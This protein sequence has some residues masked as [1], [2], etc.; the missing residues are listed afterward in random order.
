MA[1]WFA[2]Y[3]EGFPRPQS[4]EYMIEQ[5]AHESMYRDLYKEAQKEIVYLGGL[6]THERHA[7]QVAE[8]DRQRMM[9]LLLRF[10]TTMSVE[11]R[12]ASMTFELKASVSADLLAQA[13]DTPAVIGQILE[14]LGRQAVTKLTE[15]YGRAFSATEAET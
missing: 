1:D 9:R 12:K 3:A 14:K 15:T 13:N 7:R 6:L 10:M 2:N 5:D 8:A 4:I 11:Q